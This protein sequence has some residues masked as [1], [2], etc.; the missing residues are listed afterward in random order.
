MD[1]ALLDILCCPATQQPL[2]PM[3]ASSLRALNQRITRGEVTDMEGRAVTETWSAALMTRDG[4]LAY[5][6]S[7]DIPILLE[8]HSVQMRL[9]DEATRG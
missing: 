4:R 9:G 1:N 5:P 6:I 3:K 7:D 8:G 2:V